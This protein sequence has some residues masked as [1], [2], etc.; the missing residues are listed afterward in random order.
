MGRPSALLPEE[1]G[2]S[3][4]SG[5]QRSP[6]STAEPTAPTFS[7]PN[8]QAKSSGVFFALLMRQGLDWCWSN[9]SDCRGA[10]WCR[11]S[12]S[13]RSPASL[14]PGTAGFAPTHVPQRAPGRACG[15]LWAL[16]Y[17]LVVAVLRR[18]VQRDLPI[19][20]GHVDGGGSAEQHPHGLHTALPRR[21]VQGPHPCGQR[22]SAGLDMAP[23]L[24]QGAALVAGGA[25]PRVTPYRC[26]P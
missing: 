22:G 20:R 7:R 23:G 6:W 15:W 24:A 26:C 10:M 21:V 16:T 13:P 12:A 1:P 11:G 9:I 19:Q 5:S 4:A 18:E 8:S 17:H 25:V 3:R 14:P 2:G